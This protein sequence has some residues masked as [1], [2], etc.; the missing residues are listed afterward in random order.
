MKY[1]QRT[2]TLN[3]PKPNK[4]HAEAGS[5]NPSAL[6]GVGSRDRNRGAWIRFLLVLT[7]T[8]AAP[9]A[10]AQKFLP[11]FEFETSTGDTITNS[12]LKGKVVLINFWAT[13]CPPCRQEMPD[14]A[15][16]HRKYRNRGFLV[17]GVS[18]DQKGGWSRV[19][20]YIRGLKINFPV[21]R[22]YD[23]NSSYNRNLVN[24]QSDSL[25]ET[26]IIDRQSKIRYRYVGTRSRSVF[27]RRIKNLL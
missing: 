7:F 16:L 11:R 1:A 14:L 24:W 13:W 10:D 9:A 15:Y 2:L 17:L 22:M 5:A 18:M 27:E 20:R 6:D 4:E 12:V 21:A 23:R 25:P 19:R 8:I 3:V 26:W